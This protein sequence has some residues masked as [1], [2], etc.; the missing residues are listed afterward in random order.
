M[1]L[2]LYYVTSQSKSLANTKIAIKIGRIIYLYITD[3]SAV[4]FEV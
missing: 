2:K 4:L 3:S 1:T